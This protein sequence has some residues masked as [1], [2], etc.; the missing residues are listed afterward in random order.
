ML[1]ADEL[2]LM[3]DQGIKEDRRYFGRRS[4]STGRPSRR[5]VTIIN[6]ETIAGHAA[7]LGLEKIPPGEVRSNIEVTGYEVT[8]W[9]G[10]EVE[11][12][13]VVVRLHEAR[14]PCQKMD[15][16]CPGLRALMEN[17]RQ[18]VLAEIIRSGVVRIGD[19]VRPHVD[20]P[21]A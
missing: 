15:E 10:Q 20:S 9:L 5:Q 18:G 13:T 6:R 12:G 17:R 2:H 21:P 14:T 4:R 1:P 7:A 16:I 8:D 11:I 3:A 19:R